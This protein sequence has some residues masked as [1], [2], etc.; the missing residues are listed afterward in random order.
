[1]T[2][3]CWL[4]QFDGNINGRKI[5]FSAYPPSSS[6]SSVLGPPIFCWIATCLATYHPFVHIVLE[7]SPWTTLLSTQEGS[8]AM[9]LFD[10]FW[11]WMDFS[12]K[13]RTGKGRE[14]TLAQTIIRKK[15]KVKDYNRKDAQIQS[16]ACGC[17]LLQRHLVILF[18][19][20]PNSPECQVLQ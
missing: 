18:T 5:H 3:I 11:A 19:Y 15:R 8:K 13:S 20:E 12:R 6:S 2:C 9:P 17:L 10:K 7:Y 4:F 1:M 16:L 14:F